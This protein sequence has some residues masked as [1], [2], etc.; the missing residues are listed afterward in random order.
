MKITCTVIG[1]E[2][3]NRK[4]SLLLAKVDSGPALDNAL[5]EGGLL[6]ETACKEHAEFTQGYQTGRTR[7]SIRTEKV[8]DKHVIVAA[9]TYYSPYLEFGTYKMAAQPFMKPGFEA[10]RAQALEHIKAKLAAE[11]K[12]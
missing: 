9:H 3:F 2:D 10:S 1:D 12:I 4:I 6:I 7:S 8:G 5:M 11:M